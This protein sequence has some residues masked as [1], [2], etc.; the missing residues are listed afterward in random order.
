MARKKKT[1]TRQL[2][3][4]KLESLSDAFLNVN[5][6]FLELEFN[7]L[8]DSDIERLIDNVEE[9]ENLLSK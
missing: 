6:S 7:K 4:E 2:L 1:D 9:L 3:I 8:D 5:Q